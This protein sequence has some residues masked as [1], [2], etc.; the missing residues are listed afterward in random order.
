MKKFLK[1]ILLFCIPILLHFA[2]YVIIDPFKVIKD[3]DVEMYEDTASVFKTSDVMISTMRFIKQ[4]EKYH[5]DSFIFE[6]SR[7]LNFKVKD[8][9][10]H[11][12]EPS[13]CFHFWTSNGYI[14]SWHD[15]VL[16]IDEI[17]DTI[18]NALCVVDHDM[19]SVLERNDKVSA[20]P[21]VLC[22]NNNWVDFHIANYKAFCNFMYMEAVVDYKIFGQYRPYMKKY[23]QPTPRPH[24]SDLRTNEPYTNE[25]EAKITA[26]TFY[27]KERLKSFQNA[28][29][30]GT[31]SEHILTDK[32]RL[33]I[34]EI[35]EVFDRHHTNYEIILGPQYDQIKLND[36]TMNF[37]YETFG[38]EHVHDFTGVN[39]WT[40]DYHN[41]YESSH[42]RPCV[43]KEIM[44]IVYNKK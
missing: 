38:R 24:S 5:Y 11:I 13:S 44:D 43:A 41:Y 29:K 40:S 17:G 33:L 42:Y 28:Q 18:K 22:H 9:E 19:L 32:E 23:I 7:S 37:L 16:F 2:A 35:R 15:K 34:R 31:F 6:N 25:N 4:R 30:P 14:K 21:P 27:D 12:S 8:W 26:G 36:D 3:Y 20:E 1:Y 10:K 39:K